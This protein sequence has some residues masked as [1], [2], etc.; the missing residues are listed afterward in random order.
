MSD[1][2][3]PMMGRTW[4]GGNAIVDTSEGSYL[5][6]EV[7]GRAVEKR[8]WRQL[9]AEEMNDYFREEDQDGP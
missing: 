4:S 1:K 8:E 2:T 5:E 3:A 9:A 7:K 6:P